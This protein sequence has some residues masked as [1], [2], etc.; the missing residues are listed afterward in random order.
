MNDIIQPFLSIKRQTLVESVLERG[1]CN[2][3]ET[4]QD[5]C[6][7]NWSGMSKLGWS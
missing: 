3:G 1:S 4:S 7:I 5:C 2:V 6:P